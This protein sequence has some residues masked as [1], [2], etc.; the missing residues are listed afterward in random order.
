M[1]GFSVVVKNKQNDTSNT[2]SGCENDMLIS[3]LKGKYAEII[4]WSVNDI[5]FVCGGQECKDNETL[6]DLGISQGAPI[7]VV[8]QVQGGEIQ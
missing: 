2:I 1:D 7:D 8:F 5:R 6:C 4:E 3:E